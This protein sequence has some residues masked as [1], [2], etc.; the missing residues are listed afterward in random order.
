MQNVPEPHGQISRLHAPKNKN[1]V[2][3]LIE[4]KRSYFSETLLADV[5]NLLNCNHMKNFFLKKCLYNV[6]T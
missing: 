1:K 4:T 5:T 3:H 6:Q 2:N